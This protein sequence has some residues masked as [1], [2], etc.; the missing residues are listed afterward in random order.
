MRSTLA[1]LGGFSISALGL[2]LTLMTA[3]DL[4]GVLLI[5]AGAVTAALAPRAFASLSSGTRLS[6]HASPPR[7]LGQRL[8]R[9]A[10][11]KG[12]AG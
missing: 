8:A 2:A 4:V 6:T 11:E 10:A 5:A 12:R 3:Y 7:T 1:L 9:R